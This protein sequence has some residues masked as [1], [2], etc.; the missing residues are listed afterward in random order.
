MKTLLDIDT[1]LIVKV[2]NPT[3]GKLRVDIRSDGPHS[4]R[5]TGQTSSDFAVVIKAKYLV[6]VNGTEHELLTGKRITNVSFGWYFH[7]AL[8]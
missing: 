2:K 4:V 7:A 5:V 8:I 6:T 1:A 3:P